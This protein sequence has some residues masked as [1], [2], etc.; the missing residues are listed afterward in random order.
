MITSPNDIPNCIIWL[1]SHDR[2]TMF[3]D[4]SVASSQRRNL[5][6][7]SNTIRSVGRSD[8]FTTDGNWFIT[9]TV[10][11][12]APDQSS[13]T[14]WVVT[15]G[16]RNDYRDDAAG[17]YRT[18]T[19]YQYAPRTATYTLSF[20]VRAYGFNYIYFT[21]DGVTSYVRLDVPGVSNTTGGVTVNV[22][23]ASVDFP[24]TPAAATGWVRVW[25]TKT[26]T[27]SVVPK[28]LIIRQSTINNTTGWQNRL[29]DPNKGYGIWGIMLE[30]SSSLGSFIP[31]RTIEG[32]FLD[33]TRVSQRTVPITPV[34]AGNQR[35]A[36]WKNKSLSADI[37]QLSGFQVFEENSDFRPTLSV[38]SGITS[39]RVDY[40]YLST[41]VLNTPIDTA[42]QTVF[43]VMY[44]TGDNATT[45]HNR[46]LF[47]QGLSGR[48]GTAYGGANQTYTPF[49]VP[50]Q[51]PV[52]SIVA[53][54]AVSLVP[55]EISWFTRNPT[56]YNRSTNQVQYD[57]L[58]RN[59]LYRATK[60]SNNTYSNAYNR[61][62]NMY[63]FGQGPE[64]SNT[65]NRGF[66]YNT[67]TLSSLSACDI[68]RLGTGF[69]PFNLEHTWS[70]TWPMTR[71][72][73]GYR[74]AFTNFYE[75]IFY[76][77]ELT[78]DEINDVEDY[79]IRKWNSILIGSARQ[80][81]ALSDGDLSDSS[82]FSISSEPSPF[83]VLLSSDVIYT[84]GYT[85]TATTN[86]R[87]AIIT[88]YMTPTTDRSGGTVVMT[89]GV[90]LSAKVI[91]GCSP[92]SVFV[93]PGTACTILGNVFGGSMRYD[94]AI[95]R[96]ASATINPGVFISPGGFLS[97]SGSAYGG[98]DL[99]SAG[100]SIN[101][102]GFD[103][104]GII[105]GSGFIGSSVHWTPHGGTRGYGVSAIN[106]N[107]YL[108]NRRIQSGIATAGLLTNNCSVVLDN[109]V[110]ESAYNGQDVYMANIGTDRYGNAP[111]FGNVCYL[112]SSNTKLT[113]IN[114]MFL[115][116]TSTAV[117]PTAS[118]GS[119]VPGGNQ[120]S[121]TALWA[122]GSNI[123]ILLKD[124][125]IEGSRRVAAADSGGNLT[126]NYYGLNQA[127]R[128][129]SGVQLTGFN[130]TINGARN[131]SLNYESG[132]GKVGLLIEGGAQAMLINTNVN[133]QPNT[134]FNRSIYNLG[135]LTLSGTVRGGYRAVGTSYPGIYN[136][137]NLY[138]D[139]FIAP[140][141]SGSAAIDNES[142][143]RAVLYGRIRPG[144][145]I[146]NTITSR[147]MLTAFYSEP[148]I[149]ST[150]GFVPIAAVQCMFVSLCSNS[151]YT[152][153]SV[154]GVQQTMR[155]LDNDY[156]LN[157]PLS[158][159]VLKDY[160]Y[161]PIGFEL[162]GTSIIPEV[163]ATIIGV[164]VRSVYGSRKPLTVDAF[165]NQPITSVTAPTSSIYEKIINPVTSVSLSAITLSLTDLPPPGV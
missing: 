32:A 105:E 130:C 23:P 90:T 155:F 136:R 31:V 13:A 145:P 116:T 157:Q 131:A 75:V 81:W 10:S 102:G 104:T 114:T 125:Y 98:F 151:L 56:A 41:P 28:E 84:N 89:E 161:G 120:H 148:L 108:K 58:W 142:D 49:V 95:V 117:G 66:T 39:L 71:R 11:V 162:T 163:S 52:C 42:T 61:M 74:G 164:P 126:N 43:A 12:S 46:A 8:V 115:G 72:N 79:L 57:H 119:V 129:S 70:L 154:D 63:S 25:L 86:Q 127:M 7:P 47:S 140:N 14:T 147:G 143:G 152:Q 67:P 113:A 53:A 73:E 138:V 60:H 80:V 21:F 62:G 91:G 1:D 35:V 45:E 54:S 48:G 156:N 88:N 59:V 64:I 137:G 77:R 160:V 19:L 109:C 30:E 55:L 4:I 29:G 34:T 134:V 65:S 121:G 87:F 132:N 144:G 124:C 100:I 5:Y 2:T 118:Y 36:Y 135:T 3:Q 78:K 128:I 50:Y 112:C 93:P 85:L 92:A 110:V 83:N 20:F 82:I 107:L 94:T 111:S 153:F 96:P 18:L 146:Q 165:W 33:G 24:S 159:D 9:T 15:D 139:G 97:L 101:G 133:T 44:I 122:T 99:G 141:Y 103:Y 22:R 106:T 68:F 150:R 16:N 37:V 38:S 149:S 76:N 123:N 17:T 69:D 51:Y 6:A 27:G 40:D 26:L 158:S